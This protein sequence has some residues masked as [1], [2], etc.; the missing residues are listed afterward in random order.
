MLSLGHRARASGD[1][2]SPRPLIA[3][4]SA[5]LQ[6]WPAAEK[7]L[8]LLDLP[9]T[10]LLQNGAPLPFCFRRAVFR[11]AGECPLSR[12]D[13]SCG[14]REQVHEG[15]LLIGAVFGGFLPGHIVRRG[16]SET[17]LPDRG[18]GA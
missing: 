16:I 5:R 18:G 1:D 13:G 17:P 6:H 2:I 14:R 8:A 11:P 3:S 12:R 15:C 10:Q 7:S 9:S 4:P